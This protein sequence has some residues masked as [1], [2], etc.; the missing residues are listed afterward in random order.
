MSHES[1]HKLL[2]FTEDGFGVTEIRQRVL[3]LETTERFWLGLNPGE[4]NA[5][6]SLCGRGLWG[7]GCCALSK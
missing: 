1:K 3:V 2:I 6:A 4:G 5:Y 7:L